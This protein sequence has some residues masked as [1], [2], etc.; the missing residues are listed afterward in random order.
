[1]AGE[2]AAEDE[3]LTTNPFSSGRPTRA[4]EVTTNKVARLGIAWLS[5]VGGNLIRSVALV[6]E[7]EQDQKRAHRD[8]LIDSLVDRAVQARTAK[9][10]MPSMQKLSELTVENA[11]SLFMSRCTSATSAP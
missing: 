9:Q 1:M 6:H 7:A 10:K 2:T 5:P 8:A 11:T 3:K 4:S